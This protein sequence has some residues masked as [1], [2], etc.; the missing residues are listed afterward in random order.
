[1]VRFW[2]IAGI[3]VAVALGLFYGDFLRVME[4]QADRDVRGSPGARRRGRDGRR[5]PAPRRCCALGARGDRRSTGPA[6]RRAGSAAPRPAPTVVLARSRRRLGAAGRDRRSWSSRP[7]CRRTRPLARG[8]GRGRDRRL[9]RA[10]AGLA[11][12]RRRARRPG[13]RSPAPTARRPRSRCW[14]RSCARPGC[15]PPRSATSAS[16]WCHAALAGGDAYDVLAVELS[17]FQLHWSSTLAPQVGALLN[18]A[19]D[20]LEWHG[21]FEAYAAAKFAIWRSATPAAARR[22]DRQPGRPRW[23]RPA[24]ARGHRP[25]GRRSRSACRRRASS[26]SST[27]CWSTAWLVGD[28]DADEPVPLIEATAIRPAGRAQRGQ[29]AGRRRDGPGVRSRSGRGPGRA[30]RIPAR[31]APQRA[32]GHDRRASR[33]STTARR[34]TRTPRR[35]SLAAYPPIVWVAGGQLKGVDIDDLVAPVADRLRGAVLLGV[36]R[37]ESSRRW[38]DTPR[39]S[40]SSTWR[41]RMMGRWPRWCAPRRGWRAPGDT[42]LLAPAAASQGHVRELRAPR[43]RVRRGGP[44]RRAAGG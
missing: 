24:L 28:G 21:T 16:R 11:A 44:R 40:P 18:L 25:R 26:A 12:A 3:G 30:G 13:S 38:R 4:F 29:R 2:I 20:H 17:S 7:A 36:D 1:M 42:V 19:D 41:G 33:T 10:G 39:T 9:L 31:A 8:R 37:A 23:S 6:E 43:R 32:G 34:P 22:R 14:R 15:G 35:A 27:A 5:R